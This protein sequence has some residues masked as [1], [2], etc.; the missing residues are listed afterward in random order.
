M[1]A[2]LEEPPRAHPSNAIVDIWQNFWD[3]GF[4]RKDGS[5]HDRVGIVLLGWV[6]VGFCDIIVKCGWKLGGN[7]SD[8]SLAKR[9]DEVFRAEAKNPFYKIE[10]LANVCIGG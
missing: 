2:L 5:S 3:I 4:L 6:S 7:E 9:T 1:W 8:A 10:D